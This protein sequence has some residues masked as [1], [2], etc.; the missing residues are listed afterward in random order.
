MTTPQTFYDHAMNGYNDGSPGETPSLGRASQLWSEAASGG[1]RADSVMSQVMLAPGNANSDR[2]AAR[3]MPGGTLST[4]NGSSDQTQQ[5]LM[6][7]KM[8][9]DMPL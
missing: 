8:A 3:I 1:Y 7:R 5:G 4:A 9:G 2:D 6:P